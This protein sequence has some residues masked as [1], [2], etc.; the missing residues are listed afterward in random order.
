MARAPHDPQRRTERLTMAL[1]S[2][3]YRAAVVVAGLRGVEVGNLLR[4]VSLAEVLETFG[5][6]RERELEEVA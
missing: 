2:D 3:E 5:R 4:E 6:I 1:T